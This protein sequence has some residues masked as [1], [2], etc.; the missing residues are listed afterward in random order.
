MSPM[1]LPRLLLAASAVALLGGCSILGS[2]DKI[3][4]TLYSPAVQVKVDPAW[5]QADWQLVVSKPSAARMVDSPRINVRPTPSEL[6]IYKGASWAQ[7]ATDIIEDT[8]LR[9]FEDSG[10]LR[11]VARTA[12][13]IRADY[14]LATDIRRFESDYQGQAT[15][16][17]VIEVNA[18]LIHTTDQRVVADRTFRQAQPVGST[19]VAAVAAA[20]ERGLQQ[21]AQDVV[22]WTLVN[23]QSD[24]A[25]PKR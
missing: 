18:K 13:G 21:L 19:D 7:P 17:V 12:A 8:L 10:R 9:G 16:T 4:V 25:A 23:G 20:F 15:P 6:E 1:T 2:G 14:K 3:P 5:P 24:T 11:G 22:G